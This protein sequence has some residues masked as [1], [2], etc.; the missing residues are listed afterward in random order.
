LYDTMADITIGRFTPHIPFNPDE[1]VDNLRSERYLKSAEASWRLYESRLARILYYLVRPVLG[2]S[3]RKHLQRVYLRR[4][5]TF[6][7]WPVDRSVDCLLENLLTVSLKAHGVER[8]PF[9]WFWPEGFPSCAIMTHD[10]ETQK[11]RDFCADLMDL[12]DAAA[13]KSSF[14]I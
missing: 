9:I 5:A 10:V 2:V 3:L 14:E 12:D 4:P 6:P 11:G 8:I 7:S 1:I 13:I